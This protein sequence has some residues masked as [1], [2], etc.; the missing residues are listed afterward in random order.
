MSELLTLGRARL[1]VDD[2]AEPASP[3]QPKRLALLAYIALATRRLPARRDALRALFWPELGDEEGR[4]A[5]RQALHYLRRAV[6]DVFSATAEEVGVREEA[7]RCDALEFERLADAGQATE[8]LELYRRLRRG[9][10]VKS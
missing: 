5:L 7:L 4:R 2:G 8:A 6:G 3:A 1:I 9:E 10:L